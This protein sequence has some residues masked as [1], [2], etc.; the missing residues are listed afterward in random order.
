MTNGIGPKLLS[1]H[2]VTRASLTPSLSAAH[3][4]AARWQFEIDDTPPP[5]ATYRAAF[6]RRMA[7]RRRRPGRLSSRASRPS[8]RRR[9]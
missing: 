7:I 6:R 5:A 9:S 3:P 2:R 4:F 8:W 1:T